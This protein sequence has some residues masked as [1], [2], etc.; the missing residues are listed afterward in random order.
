LLFRVGDLLLGVGDLP[1]PF[2]YLL[3]EFLNLMLLLLD[4]P[5]QFFPAVRMRVR[6][7]TCRYLL[8]VCASSGARI[9]PPYVKRFRE[10]CP[11]KSAGIPGELPQNQ[12]VNSYI[13][14]GNG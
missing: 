1:I 5:L 11:E 9:H 6:T 2:D 7:P 14:W 10:I 12:G 3:A 13:I 8:V 4:L